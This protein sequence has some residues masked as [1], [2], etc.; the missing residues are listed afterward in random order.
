MTI[1]DLKFF[2]FGLSKK[3]ENESKQEKKSFKLFS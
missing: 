3:K 2:N 1:F